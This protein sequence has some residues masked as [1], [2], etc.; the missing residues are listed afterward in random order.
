[1]LPIPP[2][3]GL[4]LYFGT[5]MGYAFVFG[6]IMGYVALFL[7]QFYSLIIALVI[8]AICY[9]TYYLIFEKGAW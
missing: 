6:S 1:M 9:V 7:V 4:Q 3:P 8:G 5:R 2:L